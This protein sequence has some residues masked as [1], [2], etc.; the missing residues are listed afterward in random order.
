MYIYA[1]I[2][3]Y[4]IYHLWTLYT[5]HYVSRGEEQRSRKKVIEISHFLDIQK[6]QFED[7]QTLLQN[8]V[9]S[10]VP[11][12]EEPHETKQRAGPHTAA[13]PQPLQ[14][15]GRDTPAAISVVDSETERENRNSAD[16]TIN[17]ILALQ[18]V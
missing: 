9:A 18:K 16:G 5:M 13:V 1:E 8:A 4:G 17:K 10:L 2:G 3:R 14:T 6:Q 15:D 11:S 7:L 12:E